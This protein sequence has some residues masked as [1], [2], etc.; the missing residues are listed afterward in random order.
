MV[1]F[2][3]GMTAEGCSS[4]SST[5]ATGTDAGQKGTDSGHPGSSSGSGMGV[6]PGTD[7]GGGTGSGSGCRKAPPALH[8]ETKAGVYCPFSEIGDGG[9]LTCAAGQECCVTPEGTSPSTCETFSATDPAASCKVMGSTVIECEGTPDCSGTTGNICCGYGHIAT[10]AACTANG[11]TVPEYPYVS[12]FA[13]G[14]SDVKGSGGTFCAAT[15]AATTIDGGALPTFQVCSQDSECGGS[16]GVCTPVEPSGVGMGYCSTI[17]SGAGTG[18]GSSSGSGSS[19]G[20]GGTDAGSGSG[21]STG[22]GS[23][24]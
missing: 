7:G 17:G 8:A 1:A 23:G 21:S 5:G 16:G 19:S 20:T 24:T 14:P 11:V 18:P 12:G 13:Y 6:T 3:L 9:P 22:S 4:S 15:C 2:G 10:Q